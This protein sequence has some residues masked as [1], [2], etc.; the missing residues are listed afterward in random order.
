ME[1]LFKTGE[2]NVPFN[3]PIVP[4]VDG[5]GKSCA[6]NLTHLYSLYV[7]RR[8]PHAR[9][10]LMRLFEHKD[11]SSTNDKKCI[12][13]RAKYKHG[14]FYNCGQGRLEKTESLLVAVLT[15]GQSLEMIW[16]NLMGLSYPGGPFNSTVAQWHKKPR[17]WTVSL[18]FLVILN[19]R[20]F[21]WARTKL[22]LSL[23][24]DVGIQDTNSQCSCHARQDK[25]EWILLIIP[26]KSPLWSRGSNPYSVQGFYYVWNLSYTDVQIFTF[27]VNSHWE[28]MFCPLTQHR[29]PNWSFSF[30][31]VL[32]FGA[33]KPLNNK[34]IRE[35]KQRIESVN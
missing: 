3:F 14:S 18:C 5:N 19:L 11:L 31:W 30:W 7:F 32:T 28:Q 20:L 15:S 9:I 1:K 29:L 25:T 27:V 23:H 24:A 2:H 12:Y 6:N 22:L 17:L 33:D 16:R 35:T 4:R 26:D 34:H 13:F 10:W 21:V 8:K